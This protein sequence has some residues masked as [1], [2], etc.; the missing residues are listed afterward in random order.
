MTRFQI[1]RHAL[2][3][4]FAAGSQLYEGFLRYWT[5]V[6]EEFKDGRVEWR[7]PHGAV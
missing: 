5:A 7:L 6:A 2:R 4:P 1:S 3:G